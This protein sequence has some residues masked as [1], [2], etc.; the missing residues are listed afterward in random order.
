MSASTPEKVDLSKYIELRDGRA[1]IRGR[2][3]PVAF[4]AAASSR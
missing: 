1:N 3:L 4:V 2:R